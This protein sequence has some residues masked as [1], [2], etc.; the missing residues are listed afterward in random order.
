M[1]EIDQILQEFNSQKKLSQVCNDF[2]NFLKG[3]FIDTTD[4]INYQKQN[5]NYT[6]VRQITTIEEDENSNLQTYIIASFDLGKVEKIPNKTFLAN[7]SRS[8]YEKYIFVP[9]VIVFRYRVNEQNYLTFSISQ[10]R[11]K[12]NQRTGK[13]KTTKVILLKDINLEKPHPAH[14]K[15]L[16]KLKNETTAVKNFDELHENWLKVL[17]I[18]ELGDE[19]YKKILEKYNNLVEKIKLPTQNNPAE[20]V[21]K[22]FALRLVGRLIFCWFLKAKG[23]ISEDILGSKIVEAEFIR[24]NENNSYYH[25]I[26]ELLFFESLNKDPKD[27]D[28]ENKEKFASVP[29]LN[30]GLF[31]AGNNDFYHKNEK[32]SDKRTNWKLEIPN[33]NLKE[34]FELFESYYFTIDENTSTDQEIGVD[35]E[36][37]GRIF[38]NF[39][40]NRSSTGSFYTPREIVDYMVETSLLETL[41]N[42]CQLDFD[43]N[44][45]KQKLLDWIN[46]KV[47]DLENRIRNYQREKVI[48]FNKVLDTEIAI[49]SYLIAKL[50]GRR[51]NFQTK[52]FEDCNPHPESNLDIF[53]K[54]INDEFEIKSQFIPLPNVINVKQ[55]NGQHKELV[56]PKI[57]LFLRINSQEF[58]SIWTV[59]MNETLILDTIFRVY[60]PKKIHKFQQKNTQNFLELVQYFKSINKENLLKN[61]LKLY[62]DQQKIPQVENLL[63][64]KEFDKISWEDTAFLPSDEPPGPRISGVHEIYKQ[65]IQKN[66]PLVKQ[67]YKNNN[68][69]NYIYRYIDSFPTNYETQKTKE[70][71]NI[72]GELKILDPA[73]GSGA[74]PMGVLQKLTEIIHTL[75]PKKSLYEIKLQILQNSIYGVDLLPI[76]VEISR[77]RCWLSLVVDE[78]K[79]DPKPLPNLEFKFVCANSLVGIK[80]LDNAL[81]QEE[82]E[83]KQKEL[84]DFRLQTFQ[85]AQNKQELAQKWQTLTKELFDLQVDSSFYDKENS[86]DLTAWNP[87]EN[88]PAEFFD[89]EWMFGESGFDLVIG[90]PPYVGEKSNKDTFEPLKKSELG[91]RFYQGKMDLFYFFFHLGLDILKPSGILGY[92]T[93]NYYITATG[94]TKLRNDFKARSNVLKLINFGELK[95]FESALGQHNLITLLQKKNT[96]TK[97]SPHNEISAQTIITQNKGYLGSKILENIVEGKDLSTN[98]YQIPQTKL[99]DENGY[100]KLTSGGMDDVMDKMLMGSMRL[101]EIC[102][103]NKGIETGANEIYIFKEKP[104]FYDNL[105]ENERNLFKPFY[106]NSNINKYE[107]KNSEKLILYFRSD[108]QT[109]NYPNIQNYLLENKKTLENRAQI[110]RSKQNWYG[111]LWPRDEKMF[112]NKAIVAPYRSENVSFSI[113]NGNFY[114]GTDTYYISNISKEFSYETLLGILNSKLAFLWFRNRGKVKGSVLE[115]TGDNIEQLP[116]PLLN[117]PEK[118][119]IAGQIEKLVEEILLIKQK[120]ESKEQKDTANLE[121]RIDEL[122]FELYG[123]SE[124]EIA[125]ILG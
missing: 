22:D 46:M 57:G 50:K 65:I 101:G 19:F 98:Y 29:Y 43:Q 117:T 105:S 107:I 125:V 37:M 41:K 17:N 93:T 23:W 3:D 106:K 30:G 79:K 38:E 83:K 1:Q 97:N 16:E 58:I 80:H 66:H 112:M 10:I 53:N 104:D 89:P 64:T 20:N 48:L 122:V 118:Q 2:F 33:Q 49:S 27:R 88:K 108:Y 78:D 124:G 42:K 123:L 44:T 7:L 13:T 120:G 84:A 86:T 63:Q 95:I 51:F 55:E 9:F 100:M 39:I 87:F 12:T 103:V 74:F 76:A 73:C 111:L 68:V 35:P 96:E 121:S 85:P 6:I 24:Q 82:I 14:S 34:I 94:G 18:K 91:A 25:S 5:Y 62:F 77:L 92:I 31:E 56:I 28:F 110:K 54:L 60:K 119:Q 69:E 11:D 15:I 47:L 90:N 45:E 109:E 70:I 67:T 71:T 26:L 40:L 52:D 75:E 81:G 99:F 8:V 21:K 32:Q 61:L 4:T 102:E 36:M 72:L 115:M 59:G 116:I 113:S 114:S